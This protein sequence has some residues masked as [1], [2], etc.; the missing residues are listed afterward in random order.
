MYRYH[1]D[2]REVQAHDHQCQWQMLSTLKAIVWAKFYKCY[3]NMNWKEYE[4]ITK[5]IYETLGNK[6]GVAIECYG[7][8]CK[9]RGK[10]S[11]EHQIDVLTNHSDGL[12]SYKTAIECKYWDEN[13]NKDIIMKVAE[14]VEDAGLNKGVIVSKKGFTEDAIN[15]AKYKNVGLVELREPTKKD[16]EGRVKNITVE[17]NMLIPEIT[18]M[19]ILIHQNL[20]PNFQQGKLRVEFL[21]ILKDDGQ[22]EG[23]EKYIEDFSSELAKQVENEGFTKVYKFNSNTRFIYTPTNEEFPIDGFEFSGFLRINRDH[24]IEIKGEDH[25]WLIM[26]SIFEDKTFTIS[27][28]KE[29]RERENK[30]M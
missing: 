15:F 12:H 27:K 24:V 30:E 9:V 29:I 28:D 7:N 4:E 13:I 6:S 23:L 10:S 19:K 17:L 20:Q 2:R 26:K 22:R 16:W 11:V 18:G 8:N 5:Y 21:E 3:K 25:I 14:I 1:Q